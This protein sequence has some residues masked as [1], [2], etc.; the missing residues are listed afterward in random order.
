MQKTA[1]ALNQRSVASQN[2]HKRKGYP[3]LSVAS[4][5]ANMK[6]KTSRIRQDKAECPPWI[7]SEL[8]KVSRAPLWILSVSGNM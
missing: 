6:K 8:L 7:E 3:S 1:I 2:D 4:T 5:D